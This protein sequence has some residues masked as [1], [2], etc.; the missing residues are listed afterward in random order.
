VI[1]AATGQLMFHA[2]I[3]IV[4]HLL[5]S[6][7]PEKSDARPDRRTSRARLTASTVG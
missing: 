5:L 6:F 2:S 1:T 7:K 3:V 4:W